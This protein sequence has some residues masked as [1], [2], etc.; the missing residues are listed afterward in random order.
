MVFDKDAKTVRIPVKI[1]DGQVKYFYGGDLPKTINGVI[2]E[3]ILPE[4][5]IIDDVFISVSQAKYEKEILP[6]GSYIMAAVN[7]NQVEEKKRKFTETINA[8]YSQNSSFIRV[9]LLDPLILQ[10][11][12]SKKAILLDT[13]CLI[14]CLDK[15]ARSLN[16][17][18]TLISAEFEPNRRSHTGNVFSKCFY[19]GKDIWYPLENLRQLEE[20]QYEKLLVGQTTSDKTNIQ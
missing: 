13:Q 18:Y 6:A 15:E 4:Y 10:I 17:A 11:R 8:P 2:G 14:L 16:N 20:I 9:Q 3:L 7:N 5:G 19:Q 1:V 12:G